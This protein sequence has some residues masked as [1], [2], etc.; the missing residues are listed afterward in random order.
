MRLGELK[1]SCNFE[2]CVECNRLAQCL[3]VHANLLLIVVHYCGA[4]VEFLYTRQCCTIC[5][6]GA[7]CLGAIERC[8]MKK[9][10]PICSSKG[11]AMS[12]QIPLL[13]LKLSNAG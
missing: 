2:G 7:V 6:L 4:A 9:H 11:C 1:F 3:H 12:V 13:Q 10:L 8:T 5:P